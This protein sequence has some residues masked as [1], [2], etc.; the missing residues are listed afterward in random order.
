MKVDYL[1]SRNTKIGSRAISWASSKEIEVMKD[2]DAMGLDK[3]KIPSHAAVLL[4]EQLVV[5]STMSTGIRII[6]YK[7]WK[8][9]NIEVAKVPCSKQFMNSEDVLEHAIDLWGKKYDWKGISY[10]TCCFARLALA[11][12][13]LPSENKWEQEDMYFC[14]EFVARLE[15]LDAAMMT[16]AKMMIM[17]MKEATN[18]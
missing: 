7:Q 10:F 8:E 12:K 18:G 17:F 2:F 15:D 6:P 13:S 16:P 3:S 1:F 5:E 11:G 4:N 9:H 14:T